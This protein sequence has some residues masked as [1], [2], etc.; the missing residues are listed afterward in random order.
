LV[1]GLKLRGINFFPNTC[2][3][4][5]KKNRDRSGPF[6][7]AP[8]QKKQ[9][10]KR[11]ISTMHTTPSSAPLICDQFVSSLS[12]SNN[13]NICWQYENL[14]VTIR[15]RHS[16][17]VYPKQV[18]NDLL[19]VFSDAIFIF[20]IIFQAKSSSLAT[21]EE[22]GDF[23]IDDIPFCDESDQRHEQIVTDSNFSCSERWIV[24]SMCTCNKKI[25]QCSWH[26]RWQ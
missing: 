10:A 8:Y 9:G 20:V 4:A 17:T 1:Q 18:Y 24:C 2:Y 19:I 12:V 5:P 25:K 26:Y 16:N 15:F 7:M 14:F 6:V 23:V 21:Y 22:N 11:P 13:A 3:P